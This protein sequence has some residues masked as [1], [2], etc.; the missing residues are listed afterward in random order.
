MRRLLVALG[1]AA[2]LAIG[3]ATPSFA[4]ASGPA[5]MC[6]EGHTGSCNPGLPGSRLYCHP[7]MGP[8]SPGHA[9]SHAWVCTR[10]PQMG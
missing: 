10:V 9:R 2:L 1:I 6:T 8:A 7:V 4:Q 3:A 5:R